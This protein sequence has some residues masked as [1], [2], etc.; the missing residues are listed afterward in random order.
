MNSRHSIPERLNPEDESGRTDLITGGAGFIGS[1]LADALIAKGRNVR[2][3]DNF[4]S[5]KREN[6]EHVLDRIE[7]VEGDLR[8]ADAV[9]QAVEGVDVIFHQAAVASVPRSISDPTTTFDANVTGTLNLLL[10]ARDAGARRVVFASSSSIYGDTP[11][12][13]KVES[14]KPE[15]LSPYAISK[16][17][18]EQLCRVF[19]N[20]YGLE[21]VALRYF[22]VFGPRQDP[23]SQ[24]A[25]V[26][27]RFL[28]ALRGGVEPVI[29]GDGEQ[30]RDF[31]FIENV[32]DAN[33][34]AASADGVSGGVFNVASGRAI[35]VNA[36]LTQLAELVGVDRR[37][38]FEPPRQGDVRDSLADITAARSLLGYEPNVSF[39][40]G[41]ERLVAHAAER[42]T[43]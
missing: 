9:R 24:Y 40:A 25:A 23:D 38:R 27:P 13:P 3:L 35:S 17:T 36:M 42:A 34:R 16:L 37:A 5:G 19:T 15:P 8:D 11:T 10:A 39:E 7:L 29:Y 14:M 22:N 18:G 33:L 31:T 6:L 28:A 41:L 32:V 12:L 4:S 43:V 2:I 30:S 1:H 20:V 26:I 21:T